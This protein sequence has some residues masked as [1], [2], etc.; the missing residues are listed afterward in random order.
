M[1]WRKQSHGWV[2]GAWFEPS[3]VFP[4]KVGRLLVPS[5]L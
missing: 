4:A 3:F 2:T 5:S 1:K